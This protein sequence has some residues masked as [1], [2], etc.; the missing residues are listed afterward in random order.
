MATLEELKARLLVVI[1]GNKAENKRFEPIKNLETAAKNFKT[2]Q[3]KV[4]S[5]IAPQTAFLAVKKAGFILPNSLKI[6]F[7]QC[8]KVFGTAEKQEY[9]GIKIEY[10]EEN[11]VK[12]GK[13]VI[14]ASFLVLNEEECDGDEEY[15]KEIENGIK[16]WNNKTCTIK[17]NPSLNGVNEFIITFNLTTEKVNLSAF[18]SPAVDAK[19]FLIPE[20][21]KNAEHRLR[22]K[23]STAS[24]ALSQTRQAVATDNSYDN[25]KLINVYQG[26]SL[27]KRT[28]AI[29]N[30]QGEIHIIDT[31]GDI[32][33]A[34]KLAAVENGYL[35]HTNK[36]GVQSSDGFDYEEIEPAKNS[37]VIAHEI[38][39]ILGLDDI[40][41]AKNPECEFFS[42][43]GIMKYQTGKNLSP[44]LQ[45][46]SDED[47]K[48]IL[49]FSTYI[50]KLRKQNKPLSVY[51]PFVLVMSEVQAG[52]TEEQKIET[53]VTVLE[54]L[55]LK[56]EK[57]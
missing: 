18:Q 53:T 17:A 36:F 54:A 26:D 22:A 57:K 30:R 5:K 10:Y 38:G 25:L 37:D 1:E 4:K 16:Q 31:N 33:N 11:G 2:A 13:I 20:K 51:S 29:R 21:I 49:R 15:M 6:I 44:N 9:F 28:E 50:L 55:D 43:M 47:V 52:E 41:S 12:K 27:R 39:H 8:A 46:V 24:W 23:I 34:I 14:L 3:E 19:M 7:D 45:D 32:T 42:E 40:C 56:I 48:L 35:M